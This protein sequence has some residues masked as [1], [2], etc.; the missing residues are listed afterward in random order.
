MSKKQTKIHLFFLMDPGIK[1]HW[2]HVEQ[3]GNNT[4]KHGK[5]NLAKIPKQIV[6][7]IWNHRE[8]GN[9]QWN[10]QRKFI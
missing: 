6:S 5:K 9:Y 7:S 4:E 8:N 2:D 3:E 1:I 10:S